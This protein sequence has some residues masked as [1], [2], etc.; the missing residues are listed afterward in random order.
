MQFYSG[1]IT[2][3]ARG[4]TE[5]INTGSYNSREEALRSLVPML[6][7]LGHLQ[8]DAYVDY[9]ESEGVSADKE[10]KFVEG[11]Q[12]SIFLDRDLKDLIEVCGNS[13]KAVEGWTFR[14]VKN[15]F[16][17]KNILNIKKT[18]PKSTFVVI[19]TDPSTDSR[20]S[21]LTELGSYASEKEAIHALIEELVRR[22]Y[23]SYDYYYDSTVDDGKKPVKESKFT[24]YV[25]K[26]CKTESEL[27]EFIESFGNGNYRPDYGQDGW[28][29]QLI[30][31][32]G[33]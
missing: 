33:L 4:H 32:N 19:I 2:T 17:D 15:E 27:D 10:S 24:Q 3:N 13:Y 26:N 1:F 7:E 31:P 18:K 30:K 14:I 5:T 20:Y 6:V 23:I 21:R 11:L 12:E 28:T 8:Y 9:M 22:Y 16:N 25:Q 29:Y